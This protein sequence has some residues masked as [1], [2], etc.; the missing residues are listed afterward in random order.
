MKLASLWGAL[1]GLIWSS[2]S[3]AETRPNVIVI[4]ADDLGYGDIEAHGNPWLRTPNLDRLRAEGVRLEDFHVDPVCT[5]TRA[6]LLTGRHSLRVGAWAVTEGRQLL[7]EHETTMAQVFAASGYRTGLFGKWHLGDAFPYAPRFRGFHE[8]VKHMAGGIDEIGN[9]VGNDYFDPVLF[10]NGKAE[11]FKGYCTEIFV[12]ETIR[13]VR[14]NR[15]RPFFVYLPL[16]AMHSP[17]RVAETYWRRFAAE[18]P[19]NRARFY[20]M[21]ENFDHHLGRLLEA[22]E[23]E[24]LH[25]NPIVLF[26]GDNG[27]A[28][29][30]DGRGR[31]GFNAGMRG[32]KGSVYEGG[33]RVACFVRWPEGLPAGKAIRRLTSHHDWLPTL[34]DLCELS[35][36]TGLRFDGR[37]MAPLLRGIEGDWPD[38]HVVIERQGDELECCSLN[39]RGNRRYPQYAVLTERWR[40]VNGELYD[41]LADPGQRR[42]VAPRHPD[43]VTELFAKYEAHFSDVTQHQGR[44]APFWVGAPEEPVTRI[45]VRD[46]HPTVGNVIWKPEQLAD[47]SL[48]INGF[49]ALEVRAEGRY[50]FVLSRFPHDDPKPIGAD[51]ARIRLGEFKQQILLQPGDSRAVFRVDLEPG[52]MKLETWFANTEAGVERGAYFVAVSRLL[53]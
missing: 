22:L 50:E 18:H 26:M 8:V 43:V 36:P 23:Q 53:E 39:P 32:K 11:P 16:N 40:L 28:A 2:L 21:I 13:F 3:L 7:D 34:V 31:G 9:P 29:G 30:A 38:R 25:E 20:G 5:P 27:T 1:L 6:S 17:F 42:N 44:H 37:S 35:E 49:W 33:H 51:Q 47:E 52:P 46:W 24:G 14:E 10:R 48:S 12:S 4:L 15:A 19:E 45:T 41:R